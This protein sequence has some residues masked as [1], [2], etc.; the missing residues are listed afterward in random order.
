MRMSCC[1]STRTGILHARMTTSGPSSLSFRKF[2]RHQQ[3]GPSSSF[4]PK[5]KH[6]DS[7][8]STAESPILPPR[9]AQGQLASSEVAILY[10]S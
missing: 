4:K 5:I 6:G 2:D 8:M 1:K 9:N 3:S 7:A 10:S